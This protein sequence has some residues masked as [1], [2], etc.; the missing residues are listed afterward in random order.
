MQIMKLRMTGNQGAETSTAE[1]V[2]M[3]WIGACLPVIAAAIDTVMTATGM[4]KGIEIGGTTL[5][6]D[7]LAIVIGEP[8]R[9]RETTIQIADMMLDAIRG[10]NE[11]E[12]SFAEGEY[13]MKR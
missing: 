10:R 13:E 2:M 5:Q 6:K 8:G 11:K 1:I 12:T 9:R 7:D 3:I 4:V